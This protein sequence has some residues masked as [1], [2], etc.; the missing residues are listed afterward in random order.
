[1]SPIRT[2]RS[3]I[4]RR[5]TG[6]AASAVLAAAGLLATG[7]TA[8]AAIDDAHTTIWNDEPLYPGWHLDNGPARLIMQQ[9]GNL[10]AYING[11]PLWDSKTVGCGA[12]A[13]MQSDGNLV[14]YAQDGHACWASGTQ[15][16]NRSYPVKL[17]LDFTGHLTI[18]GDN[19]RVCHSTAP[20]GITLPSCDIL[21][22]SAS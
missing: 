2:N 1:M 3:S 8:N 14:V 17:L 7:G 10:V 9:D 16:G 4:A 19:G 11:Y 22:S 21:W 6:L 12:K 13:V 20:Y 5:L 15:R 18:Y